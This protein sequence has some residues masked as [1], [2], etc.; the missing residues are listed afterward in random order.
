M[1]GCREGKGLAL[2][3]MSHM[4]GGSSCLGAGERGMDTHTS[5]RV[6]IREKEAVLDLQSRFGRAMVVEDTSQFHLCFGSGLSPCYHNH[7]GFSM[8]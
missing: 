8:C 2:L 6:C 4:M 3:S 5:V 1:E 7:G